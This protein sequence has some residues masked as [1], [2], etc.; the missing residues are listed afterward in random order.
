MRPIHRETP[1]FFARPAPLAARVSPHLA[2]FAQTMR[3]A[4]PFWRVAGAVQVVGR[5]LML[6][7]PA[8]TLGAVVFAPVVARALALLPSSGVPGA[9]LVTGLMLLASLP[10]QD[11]SPS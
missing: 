6:V 3:H 11:S 7:P 2:S 10:R 9:P 1:G 8:A 5:V 4:A